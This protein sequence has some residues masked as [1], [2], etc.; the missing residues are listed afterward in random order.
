MGNPSARGLGC[1]DAPSHIRPFR[2][3]ERADESGVISVENSKI[4]GPLLHLSLAYADDQQYLNGI[5]PF[6]E[7][8][9][10]ADEPAM[11]F[12]PADRV[13]LVCRALGSTTGIAFL[14]AAIVARNPARI[15]P[16]ARLF[17]E[18]QEGSH[19]RLVADGMWPGRTSAEIREFIRHEAL[20]NVLFA[21]ADAIVLC[22]YNLSVLA[23]SVMADVT[24]THAHVL[25]DGSYQNNPAYIDPASV[26]AVEGRLPPVPDSAYRFPFARP[27]D[28]SVIRGVVGDQA[29]RFG[30]SGE[31]A[32]DLV[33]AVDEAVANTLAYTQGGG[34]LLT[35]SDGASLICQV[36]DTGH[37]VQADFAGRLRPAPQAPRGRGIWIM[38]QLCDL[39]ELASASTGTTLR[40]HMSLG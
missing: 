11:M 6:L 27:S 12:A 1:S 22:P 38:H 33:L 21:D 20:V 10:A 34:V 5:V 4:D 30:L 18:Q 39:V 35:W 19:V 31:R 17:A 2:V 15:I 29:L 16:L 7:Q 8:A 24:R 28:L 13:D 23:G 3:W 40:L 32:H 26:L 14:D 37:I 25:S 36:S 9:Q